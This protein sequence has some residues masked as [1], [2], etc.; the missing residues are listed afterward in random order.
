MAI[1]A[2]SVIHT[3]QNILLERLQNAGPGT[4]NIASEKVYELGNYQSVG[5]VYENPDLTFGMES[6]DVTTDIESVLV[7]RD[8]SV[9]EPI[10]L[11]Q[12]KLVNILTQFKPG[13]KRPDAF[14]VAKSVT[15]PGLA[16]ESAS[17]RF[18]LRENATQTFSLRGD[19]IYY[20][21]GAAYMDE[22]AGTG[23]AGQTLVTTHPAY[24]FEDG[25]GVR[26]ILAIV[27]GDKRLSYGPDFTIAN[28]AEVDGAAIATVTLVEAVAVTD[29]IRVMYSSPDTITYPQTVHTPAAVKPAAIRGRDIDVYVGGYDPDDIEGSAA[30]KWTGV[31]AVTVDWRVTL[32]T[33]EEFGNYSAV[34]RTFDVPE[35]SGSVDLMPRDPE[36]FYKKLR[37]TAGIS[38][39]TRS[40]GTATAVPLPLDVVLKDG[41]N[42]GVPLKRLSVKDARFKV[43]S[44]SPRPNTSVTITVEWESDSGE[45]LISRDLTEARVATLE[46]RTGDAG[47]SVVIQGV[48]FVTVTSVKFGATEATSYVV[49]SDRQITAVAP[50]GTGKVDVTIT[51]SKGISTVV[52]A[53]EFTYA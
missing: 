22:F 40:I 11:A 16:L 37:Q 45:L 6:F 31:Q 21:Q 33:E 10:N 28:G 35:V 9:L 4:V 20:N 7:D 41:A 17:Y 29:T 51:N 43:P 26:R 52:P 1:K 25:T 50:A 53:G 13:Q 34:A 2:G 3:G 48:N 12:T 38:S 15:I 49:D 18:G 47:D 30:R 14:T 24:E 5:T 44:Y 46:P 39:T 19:S 8:P 32:E 23:L 36:D 27:I 42:G